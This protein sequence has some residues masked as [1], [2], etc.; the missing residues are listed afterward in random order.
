MDAPSEP[1]RAGRERSLRGVLPRGFGGA[2]IAPRPASAILGPV[3]LGIDIGTTRTVVSAVQRG[4]YPIASFDAG[5]AFREWIPG[6]AIEVSGERLFGWDAVARL[7]HAEGVVRSVKRAVSGLG[8]D[9]A[10]EGLPSRPSA[11]TLL[12][13]MVAHV[14]DRVRF[15]SSLAVPSGAALRAYIAVPANATS[16]QRWI[17]LEACRAAGLEVTGVINEPTAAG[18]EYAHRHL[19]P[20]NRRSPKRYVVVYDLGGG[21][22]DTSAVSLRGRHFD[23][24]ASEGI[25]RLGGDDLD[26]ELLDL[27]L[28][29]RGIARDSLSPSSVARLLEAARDAKEAMTPNG[30][31][32]MVDLTAELPEVG[33]VVL[34][35]D[36]VLA[37]CAPL[38]ARSVA[39]IERLFE[40]LPAHGIDPE[41]AR[42]LGAVYVVGGGASFVGVQKALRAKLGRKVQ[43]SPIPHAATAIGLAVAADPDAGIYVQEATTRHFGVWRE[44]DG[45]REKRFDPIFGKDV[46][47]GSERVETRRYHPRHTVGWL[48]FLEC[49]SLA[50]DGGPGGEITPWRV[51]GFPYDPALQDRDDLETSIRLDDVVSDEEILETYR[52]DERGTVSVRIENVRRGYA[53]TYELGRLS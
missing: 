53:R 20:E 43:L 50:G 28:G 15:H 52:Y 4:R 12:S 31:H 48:R 3:E 10:V 44:G 25:G 33:P 45:G 51:V 17:T 26:S 30:R 23:L 16:R 39:M 9:D 29:A 21:T 32:V 11:L 49:S 2:G 41:D 40:G 19:G 46:P 35:A 18:I 42:Q 5:G 27:A 24:L 47:V 37:V 38:V 13:E 1:C 22:F 7:P 34:D 14:A 8:A 6:L 36:A